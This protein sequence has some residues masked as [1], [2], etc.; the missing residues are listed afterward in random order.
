MLH[1][2]T[3]KGKKSIEV[4]LWHFLGEIYRS[5][6]GNFSAA[7]DA[8]RMASKLDPDNLD[9][10]KIL[11]ELFMMIPDQW[12]NAVEEHQYLIRKNPYRVDSYKALRKIYFDTR[13]YDKAWCLCATLSFLKKAD[14]EELQFF[15]QYRTKGMIRA[16]SR[17]D[18]EKW[19]KE[20]FHS[21]EDLYI[22]KIFE[23]I[24]PSV[25]KFKV[26]PQKVFGLKKKDRHDLMN[27]TIAFAKTFSYVAQVISL[28][29]MPEL[30]L[31]PDQSMGLQYAITEPPA[32]VVGQL[33]LSGFTPQDLTFEIGRHLAYYRGEHYIRWVEPTTAGLRILILS[34][35]KVVNQQFKTPPDPSGVIDQTVQI[36]NTSLTPT[37]RE[38]LSALV[39]KFISQRGD[40]DIKKWV[41]SVELTA[42]R[43]G[44]LLC[45]D[46]QSAARMIQNQS[47]T[48]GDVPAKEKIKEL[49][50]FSV[51][52]QYFALRQALGVTIGQ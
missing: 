21:D 51:S 49:V 42:C 15:E 45:N 29:F 1:R 41:N 35:I 44:F 43:C 2:I 6:M 7:A 9:R 4:N 48:V 11:A 23:T 25:R 18:N 13:Q 36:L 31:R 24:L 8:F 46:I 37:A 28:P 5:R 34:A 33:L 17:L 12:E 22:G 16:Q 47:A 38:Q 50:L 14:P 30:Y 3:G 39:R 40:V 27:S 20:L 52:E 32:S 26:Q 19:I 10:H